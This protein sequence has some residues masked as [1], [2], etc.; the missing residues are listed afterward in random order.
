MPYNNNNNQ[1]KTRNFNSAPTFKSVVVPFIMSG[2]DFKG[3]DYD[4]QSAVEV[5]TKA[6][7]SNIFDI[8][9]INTSMPK[10]V[11]FDKADARGFIDVATING[12]NLEN[13]TATINFYKKNV[14][15]ADIAEQSMVLVPVF[16]IR[17]DGTVRSILRFDLVNEMD[18]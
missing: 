1:Q 9:S 5:L 10:S 7:N 6:I 18:A 14:R 17:K 11:V 2:K 4:H 12:I 3:N 13:M 16:K 15:L 8:I